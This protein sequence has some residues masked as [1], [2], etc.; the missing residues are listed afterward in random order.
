MT[1]RHRA[2]LA[3]ARNMWVRRVF[4]PELGSAG[5]SGRVP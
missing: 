2:T 5:D 4:E 3:S 1:T